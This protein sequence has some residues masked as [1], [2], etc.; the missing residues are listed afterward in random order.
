MDL[1][2]TKCVLILAPL[3]AATPVRAVRVTRT[4]WTAA[5]PPWLR[6]PPARHYLKEFVG[7]VRERA[8]PS[9]QTQRVARTAILK[10][11]AFSETKRARQVR[12][13]KFLK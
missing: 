6:G 9:A 13:F 5:H 7:L 11:V 1:N 4:V 3:S 2:E 12:A 10:V 8:N